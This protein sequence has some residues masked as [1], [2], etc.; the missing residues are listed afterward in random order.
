[1]TITTASI[2]AKQLVSLMSLHVFASTDKVT[3]VL[4][5]IHIQR[6]GH[7]LEVS[8]TDRYCFASGHY[9]LDSDQHDEDTDEPVFLSAD[10]ARQFL[11]MVKKVDSNAIVVIG[12][13]VIYVDHAAITI[14]L[15]Q[16]T[17]KFPA[18]QRLLPTSL[19]EHVATPA[20]IVSI[21][22]SYVAKLTKIIL[23]GQGWKTNRGAEDPWIFYV[24]ADPENEL[25]SKARPR[26]VVCEPIVKDGGTVLVMIQ[27]NLMKRD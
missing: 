14:P 8:V 27:P 17:N 24:G 6:V 19:E 13:N 1:M 26:P 25:S 9:P 23:P 15:T 3:P 20:G 21:R 16:T 12:E 10:T 22:P 4:G 11:P 18:V 2:N 7:T 5:L